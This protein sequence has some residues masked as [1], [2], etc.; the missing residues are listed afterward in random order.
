VRSNGIAQAGLCRSR[1]IFR[2][3]V[4]IVGDVESVPCRKVTEMLEGPIRTV[5]KLR[6]E[7]G[8]A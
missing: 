3:H 5:A 8:V 6:R 1:H 2:Q 4:G 7:T